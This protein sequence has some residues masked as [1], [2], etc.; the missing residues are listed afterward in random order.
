MKALGE[1][2]GFGDLDQ[3]DKLDLRL[4]DWAG[5]VAL[6]FAVSFWLAAIVSA[7][8]IVFLRIPDPGIPSDGRWATL[9]TIV[10]ALFSAPTV[11]IIAVLN[12]TKRKKAGDKESVDTIPTSSFTQAADTFVKAFKS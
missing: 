6:A 8:F 4:R 2:Q 7:V 9:T 10:V 11:I 1:I 3:F 12:G 5:T